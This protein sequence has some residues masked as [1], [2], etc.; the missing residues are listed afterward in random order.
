MINALYNFTAKGLLKALSFILATALCAVILLNSAEF[1]SQFG[2]KTPYLVIVIFYGMAILW[3][4][5]IGFEIRSTLWKAIFLPL[6]G[7]AIVI[8][9]LFIFLMK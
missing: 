7:Y 6:L 1:A 9:T 8:P 4:H 5:G 2:G 3:I